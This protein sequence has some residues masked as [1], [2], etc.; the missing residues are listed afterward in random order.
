VSLRISLE[1][2]GQSAFRNLQQTNQKAK[3]TK[4]NNVIHLRT[5]PL[6]NF[7][8]LISLNE[9]YKKKLNT[10]YKKL[11]KIIKIKFIKKQKHERSHTRIIALSILQHCNDLQERFLGVWLP[12]KHRRD[13]QRDMP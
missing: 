1:S 3:D 7:R 4:E 12:T 11:Q 2:E 8:P 5:M 9:N 6:V 13:L 10:N